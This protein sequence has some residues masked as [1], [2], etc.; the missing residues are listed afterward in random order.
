M[1]MTTGQIR[2]KTQLLDKDNYIDGCWRGRAP[3]RP[4]NCPEPLGPDFAIG[5][6]PVLVNL[7]GGR[8][9]LVVGQKSGHVHALDPAQAGK[10]VW[11]T[12][13]SPG[14]ALGG[15]EFGLA[16]E[17]G[18]V[19]AGV[20]DVVTGPKRQARP[21]R[22]ERRRRRPGLERAV[23]GRSRP[24]RWGTTPGAMGRSRRR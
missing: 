16:V 22:P 20:S 6:S 19:F 3:P 8:Q 23:A 4:A 5:N 10:V 15:I 7:A 21:L 12:R 24:C 18:R 9:L 13:L 2:W 11:Q 1:D 17:G 14:S